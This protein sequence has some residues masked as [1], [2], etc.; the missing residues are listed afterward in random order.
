MTTA[1]NPGLRKGPHRVVTLEDGRPLPPVGKV[2]SASALTDEERS[3]KWE[4][5]ERDWTEAIEYERKSLAVWAGWLVEDAR[6][7]P[8]VKWPSNV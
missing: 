6:L 5:M 4:R 3:Q 7:H 8:Y 2:G 1:I